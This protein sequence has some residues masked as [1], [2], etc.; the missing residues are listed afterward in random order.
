MEMS[1]SIRGNGNHDITVN[2]TEVLI[3]DA[4]LQPSSYI[5]TGQKFA[6]DIGIA[7]VTSGNKSDG[8]RLISRNMSTVG[9]ETP[10]QKM[11]PSPSPKSPAKKTPE[12]SDVP[13][14][15]NKS[16][17]KRFHK[18]F[19][20]APV[21]EYPIESFSCAFKGD[22]LLHGQLY[23][24]HNWLC[25]Y[26]KIKA[27]GRCIEI[28]LNKVIS[29]TR[30]KLAL[31]IPNAIGIQVADHKYVFGSFMSRDSTYKKLVT[32][33]KLNQEM[34]GSE[35]LGLIPGEVLAHIDSEVTTE[36]DTTED[37]VD[38]ARPLGRV[39]NSV[40]HRRM[41]VDASKIPDS[42]VIIN[43]PSLVSQQ[44]IN[45]INILTIFYSFSL[46]LQRIPRTNMLLGVCTILVFFLLLSAMGLTY[47]ILLLQS[48][49]EMKTIWSP[50]ASI[51]IRE[52]TMSNLYWLQMESHA[53]VVR[54]LHTVLQANIH[55]LE[56]A[57][58][59]LKSLHRFPETCT[60]NCTLGDKC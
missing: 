47:K 45:C 36:S 38:A 3:S 10:T 26:S 33:W 53:S 58:L 34:M 54:H 43:Q 60:S 17:N 39:L 22:I 27:R 59:L 20:S 32:L 12:L 4:V 30:E 1:G 21:E 6:T 15:I 24:S 44:C 13:G 51:N 29:I 11:C 7:I 9:S 31:I 48:K 57:H 28:P 25:F 5:N 37:D 46:K 56:E 18:L 23:A 41:E 42:T 55:L 40:I 49:L 14:N 2:N 35:T 16:R 50:H 52:R 19:K 8:R